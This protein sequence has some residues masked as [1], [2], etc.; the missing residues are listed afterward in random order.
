MNPLH[1]D[2]ARALENNSILFLPTCLI[3]RQMLLLYKHLAALPLSRG[4]MRTAFPNLVDYL[5][6]L[7][8][9]L[10]LT[11]GFHKTP[12][13]SFFPGDWRTDR[14]HARDLFYKTA[15]RLGLLHDVLE[16]A[17]RDA[18]TGAIDEFTGEWIEL[19]RVLERK[20]ASPSCG[21]CKYFHSTNPAH[22]RRSMANVLLTL[23]GEA[24]YA[25]GDFLILLCGEKLRL[26]L[27]SAINEISR[28]S[29][30]AKNFSPDRL[31]AVSKDDWETNCRQCIE[32]MRRSDEIPV[33][34]R[35]A[36]CLLNPRKP[37]ERL[38]LKKVTESTAAGTYFGRTLTSGRF[39][40]MKK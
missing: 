26:H 17:D 27:V 11:S 6:R 38:S 32:E 22:W 23:H 34:T 4:D 21:V 14:L 10:S 15:A 40:S 29:N 5:G 24:D 12:H 19:D 1:D 8:R 33:N 13:P 37:S 3:T 2:Y 36:S 39:K 7:T 31:L 18:L 28:H 16:P 20:N 9:N 25:Q 35:G 30:E